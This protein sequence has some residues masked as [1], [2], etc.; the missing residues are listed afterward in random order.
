MSVYI[1][2]Y[3]CIISRV[4]NPKRFFSIK[5]S[6]SNCQKYPSGIDFKSHITFFSNLLHLSVKACATFS[7]NP[8]LY[9]EKLGSHV[10]RNP[11]Y[12][13]GFFSASFCALNEYRRGMRKTIIHGYSTHCFKQSQILLSMHWVHGWMIQ[14]INITKLFEL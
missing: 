8:H 5:C 14:E 9:A 12:R 13:I 2:I 4:H 7:K 6:K 1:Y 3:V 11:K 10:S